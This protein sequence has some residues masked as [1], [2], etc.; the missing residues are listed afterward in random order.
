MDW[1]TVGGRWASRMRTAAFSGEFVS[2][3]A[4]IRLLDAT[5][6]GTRWPMPGPAAALVVDTGVN[7]GWP[8]S[9]TWEGSPGA[10][11]DRDDALR[12][13]LG[14]TGPEESD[15]EP[16]PASRPS[17][18]RRHRCRPAHPSITASGRPAGARTAAGTAGTASASSPSAAALPANRSAPS[19]APD[20]RSAS[21]HRPA[22]QGH[23]EHSRRWAAHQNHPNR[24]HRSR[25]TSSNRCG[26]RVVRRA[27]TRHHL[28]RPDRPSTAPGRDSRYG[29][30]SRVAP[31]Q[32]TGSYADRIRADDLVPSRRI[33][34]ARGLAP[35]RLQGDVRARQ[36]RSVTR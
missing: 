34:P 2:L 8:S 35:R 15:Y 7:A 24:G 28:A 6:L 26:S 10:V 22:P 29:P 4:S 16:A 19:A 21:G 32:P 33:V 30:D 18:L 9:D 31:P 20:R 23:R 13:E 5:P 3:A 17:H 1:A 11:S 36:P 27:P 14:W 12:K 25:R